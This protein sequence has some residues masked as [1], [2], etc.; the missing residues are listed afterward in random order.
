MAVAR[1]QTAQSLHDDAGTFATLANVFFVVGG[2]VAA[3]G[4]V[5][6]VIDLLG[7][8]ETGETDADLAIVPGGVI[9]T[10]SF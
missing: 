2:L 6:G 5:W 10:G 8:D 7:D 1:Q 9:V 4:I 3:A